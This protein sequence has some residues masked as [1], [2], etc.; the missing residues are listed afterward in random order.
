M[1]HAATLTVRHYPPRRNA[2]RC[3]PETPARVVVMRGS[4]VLARR[5]YVAGLSEDAVKE[6]EE[7]AVLDALCTCNPHI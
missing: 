3:P 5:F 1:Y 2:R 6:C 7:E 4:R